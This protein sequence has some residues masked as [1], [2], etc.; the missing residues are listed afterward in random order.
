MTGP[1]S[2]SARYL[3]RKELRTVF[4]DMLTA[5]KHAEVLSN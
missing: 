5:L 2:A 3:D 1:R 4:P